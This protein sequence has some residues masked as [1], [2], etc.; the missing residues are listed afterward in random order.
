MKLKIVFDINRL[1]FSYALIIFIIMP[2]FACALEA[3]NKTSQHSFPF[4]AMKAAESYFND[5]SAQWPSSLEVLVPKYLRSIPEDGDMGSN[6]VVSAYDGTG[7]WVYDKLSGD[8]RPNVPMKDIDKLRYKPENF[9]GKWIMKKIE[10]VGKSVMSDESTKRILSLEKYDFEEKVCEFDGELIEN[11]KY[12]IR[13]VS[14]AKRDS[15]FDSPY[16]DSYQYGYQPERE[17]VL[18]LDVLD[19]DGTFGSVEI[20][21]NNELSYCEDGYLLFFERKAN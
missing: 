4:L 8:V 20:I 11:P 10:K 7:G 2:I 14:V 16:F 15:R 6:K 12:V 17:E 18:L 9:Y 21:D 13:A 1:T 3:S 19:K 5:N